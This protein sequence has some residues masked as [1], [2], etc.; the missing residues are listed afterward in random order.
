MM[1]IN[2]LFVWPVKLTYYLTYQYYRI[3]G[4]QT[5]RWN[6]MEIHYCQ[7]HSTMRCTTLISSLRAYSDKN[8]LIPPHNRMFYQI[9]DQ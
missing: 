4:V 5:S 3:T 1:M 8:R 6:L 9:V 2:S 7:T